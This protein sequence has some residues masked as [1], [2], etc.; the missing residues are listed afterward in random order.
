VNAILA[1]RRSGGASGTSVRSGRIELDARRIDIG[2]TTLAVHDSG[3]DAEEAI[4]F[5]HGNLRTDQATFE[6]TPGILDDAAIVDTPAIAA[7][8]LVIGA[9]H[10]R[11]AP[12]EVTRHLADA[13]PGAR[14]E[15]LETGH[16]SNLEAPGPFTELIRTHMTR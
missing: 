5:L 4:V 3:G 13:I 10:D 7:P 14:Y 12:P 15:L 11:T 8:T 9:A 16:M 6:A 2:P 1:S